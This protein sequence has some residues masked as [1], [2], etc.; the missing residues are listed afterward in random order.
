[1]NYKIEHIGYLT[2][3]IE[4]TASTFMALGYELKGTVFN[5]ERQQCRIAFVE[6]LGE[7]R[8]ELVEPYEDNEPMLKMLKKKGVTPYHVCYEVDDVEV[9]FKELNEEGWLP[10]FAPVPAPA[11]DN[12]LI[13]YMFKQEIGFVEFVNK[14]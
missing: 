13:C 5:D 9:V 11:F 3:N 14:K 7:V 1:M 4:N 6:K 8:I 2:G 10:M 12:R